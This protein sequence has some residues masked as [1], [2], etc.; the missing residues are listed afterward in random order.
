MTS[1]LLDSPTPIA[2]EKLIYG[3]DGLGRLPSGEVLFV[4]W[5]VPGDQLSI[6]RVPGTQKP[7]KGQLLEIIQPSPDRIEPSCSVFG[8]CGG[9]QWQHV[10]S[11]SQRKWKQ[12]I[13]EESLTRLGKLSNISVLETLG[14]DE[15]QWHFR[16]RAQWDIQLNDSSNR[17]ELG[18]CKAG[19][20]DVISF[21]TCWIIPSELNQLANWLQLHL[22]QNQDAASIIQRIEAM[23]NA[24][25]QILVSIHSAANDEFVIDS[26][27]DNLFLTELTKAF[28][29]V[30]GIVVFDAKQKLS[31]PV[32]RFGE[33]A[34]V[35]TIHGK[36]YRVSAGSFFQTNR[37]AAEFIL[38]TIDQCLPSQ[39][40]SLLD[41]FSGVGL[42]A[43]H[44]QDRAKR[45]VAV[46]SA[47]SSIEDARKNADQH[48]VSHIDFRSGDARKI[49]HN[50]KENFEAAIID[51]PRS[52]CQP[53]VLTW[54]NEHITRQIIYVSC[55]PTTLARDL[56]ILT[57]A[58]WNIQNIQ[59]IDMFPQSY[60]VETVVCLTR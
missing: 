12:Q 21:E 28:P 49:L 17:Y 20:H 43:L 4:P 22:Q 38:N 53:E 57:T 27:E 15:M 59:P 10:S 40:E 31:E 34:I 35:E 45:I 14:S 55:N 11:I 33:D 1:Q 24:D 46:E 2:I 32:L 48:G 30:I 42:F 58:G 25:G 36:S 9:C 41:L 50:M 3:G 5:S 19:S 7:A 51:P 8:T 37:K 6:Q 29:A 56:K 16:N 13:V 44:F 23:Q 60:H 39:S 18:Y 47:A 52:G 54:L 26:T